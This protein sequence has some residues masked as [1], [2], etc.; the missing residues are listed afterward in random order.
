MLTS[1]SPLNRIGHLSS[2][3]D[4]SSTDTEGHTPIYDRTEGNVLKK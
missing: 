2:H 4:R 1:H 3:S